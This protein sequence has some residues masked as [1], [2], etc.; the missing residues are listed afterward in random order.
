MSFTYYDTY[1]LSVGAKIDEVLTNIMIYPQVMIDG[2][3]VKDMQPDTYKRN[4]VSP[5]QATIIKNQ[6]EKDGN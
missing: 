1:K 3:A 4:K 2:K 6:I 5:D